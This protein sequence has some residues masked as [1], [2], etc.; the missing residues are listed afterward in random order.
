MWFRAVK[1]GSGERLQGS[2]AASQTTLGL[3]GEEAFAPAEQ[4]TGVLPVKSQNGGG[5]GSERGVV[6]QKA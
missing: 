6:T 2:E 4:Q 1:N 3:E 5:S